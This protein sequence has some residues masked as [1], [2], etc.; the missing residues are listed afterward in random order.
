[1][2]ECGAATADF[3]RC[4]SGVVQGLLPGFTKRL[5]FDS[6]VSQQRILIFS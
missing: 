3:I 5:S 1:V 2:E 4:Y 6:G